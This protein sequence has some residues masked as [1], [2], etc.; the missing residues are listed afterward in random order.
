MCSP[1]GS[2]KIAL[3]GD[4]CRGEGPIGAQSETI[5][6]ALLYAQADTPIAL[7]ASSLDIPVRPFGLFDPFDIARFP[8]FV[9]TISAASAASLFC[10]EVAAS[11]VHSA[12]QI[13]WR[14]DRE[15]AGAHWAKTGC[16]CLRRGVSVRVP[17][18]LRWPP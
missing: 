18:G 3:L 13:I 6:V 15:V 14:K 11:F 7:A 17:E 8:R 1:L 9:V 4:P 12:G 5:L 10:G 2:P 16:L